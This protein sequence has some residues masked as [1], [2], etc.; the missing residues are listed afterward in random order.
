MY[1]Y[2][3]MYIYVHIYICVYIYIHIYE[4]YDFRDV[5]VPISHLP[6][7]ALLV[8]PNLLLKSKFL[9]HYSGVFL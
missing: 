1:I 7:P 4:N 6:G 2:V 5:L 9:L 8:G 3:Y